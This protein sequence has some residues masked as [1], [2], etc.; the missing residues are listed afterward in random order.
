M[1][2]SIVSGGGGGSY[3]KTIK[4]DALIALRKAVG[5]EDCLTVEQAKAQ[6]YFSVREFADNKMADSTARIALS[7]AYDAGLVDRVKVKDGRSLPSYYRT[8]A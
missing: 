1:S 2:K 7:K 5:F 8:K 6:G 4:I 3:H